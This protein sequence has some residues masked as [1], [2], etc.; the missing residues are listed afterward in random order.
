MNEIKTEITDNNMNDIKTEIKE[1]NQDKKIKKSGKNKDKHDNKEK[2]K[3]DD[4]KRKRTPSEPNVVTNKPENDLILPK[5]PVKINS[6]YPN[7][8]I[9]PKPKTDKLVSDKKDEINSKPATGIDEL[10]KLYEGDTF[11]AKSDLDLKPEIDNINATIIKSQSQFK[12]DD[13]N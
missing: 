10:S 13:N 12:D 7:E 1:K 8:I 6:P 2:D 5:T 4:L 9:S 3:Q 11:N